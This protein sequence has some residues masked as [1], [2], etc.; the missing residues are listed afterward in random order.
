[1]SESRATLPDRRVLT[2]HCEQIE[3]TSLSP[4]PDP[5]WRFVDASGHEHAYLD[6]GYPTLK[7]VVDEEGYVIVEDGYPDEYPPTGHYECGECGEEIK[8]G[9]MGPSPFREFIP[10]MRSYFL[11]NEA[12]T[13]DEYR[14]IATEFAAR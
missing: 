11:D 10:G 8:P 6:R 12:I 13:E 1:M 14:T 7:W 9:M 3:V 2:T 4:R 5:A